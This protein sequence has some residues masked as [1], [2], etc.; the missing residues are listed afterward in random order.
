MVIL[1]ESDDIKKLNEMYVHVLPSLPVDVTNSI[2]Y[3][4]LKY[5]M[6]SEIVSF[7]KEKL[8]LKADLL[9]I[10]SFIGDY[11][12]DDDV[13]QLFDALKEK[14]TKHQKLYPNIGLDYHIE[15]TRID[16]G[17]VVFCII[18]R[19]D[20]Y[21]KKFVFRFRKDP[22]LGLADLNSANMPLPDNKEIRKAEYNDLTGTKDNKDGNNNA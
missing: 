2:Y 7:C 21:M 15:Q 10:R 3:N 4:K 6:Y 8:E 11:M 5:F 20:I 13:T 1:E 22:T 14:Y 18:K 9:N 12:T 19:D 16:Y 17:V